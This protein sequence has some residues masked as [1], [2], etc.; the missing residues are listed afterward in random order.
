MLV[1]GADLRL[2]M[3]TTSA[4]SRYS[5]AGH[6][7]NGQRISLRIHQH[8]RRLHRTLCR[9]G[10]AV[11][12]RR[13]LS[14]WLSSRLS[15]CACLSRLPDSPD[16]RPRRELNPRPLPNLS[17]RAGIEPALLL[18]VAW[19]RTRN[20]P[21][22]ALSTELLPTQKRAG[23]STPAVCGAPISVSVPQLQPV[24]AAGCLYLRQG[25]V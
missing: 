19:S 23:R 6:P 15:C 10:V 1:A 8:G 3:L 14:T 25:S 9:P 18:L 13:I 22:A 16:H 20:L 21:Q 11:A 4:I 2:V 12:T 24:I 5:D 7:S 17:H